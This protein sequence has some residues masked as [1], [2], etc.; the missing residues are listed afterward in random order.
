MV[1]FGA[2]FIFYLHT[3]LRFLIGCSGELKCPPIYSQFFFLNFKRIC[4]LHKRRSRI[5]YINGRESHL[6]LHVSSLPVGFDPPKS[7]ENAC[8]FWAQK[9]KRFSCVWSKERW[10]LAFLSEK[11]GPLCGSGLGFVKNWTSPDGARS[12]S[13]SDS[14]LTYHTLFRYICVAYKY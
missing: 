7:Q 11:R 4:R 2:F 12:R 8:I 1:P 5:N 9:T 13:G 14:R 10:P 6:R 3:S